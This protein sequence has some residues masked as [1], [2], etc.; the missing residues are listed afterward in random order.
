MGRL[1]TDKKEKIRWFERARNLAVNGKAQ[2]AIDL[3]DTYVREFRSEDIDFYLLK[4][5]VLEM[6]TKYQK[7]VSVYRKVLR[8]DP[9]N[10]RA[11]IDLGDVYSSS[12]KAQYQTALFYYNRAL[13]LLKRGRFYLDLDEEIISACVGIADVLL[14][15]RRPL[16]ACKCIVYGLQRCP[17]DTL[18]VDALQR[19]KA[20]YDGLQK[21]GRS[22]GSK[23]R[24]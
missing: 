17:A 4:G 14:E 21:Q 1:T 20:A 3:I 5:S 16:D 9:R 19:S 18:L 10:V 13:S 8:L 11:M 12:G 24:Q 6:Q 15:L 7:A 22:K 2:K 23:G